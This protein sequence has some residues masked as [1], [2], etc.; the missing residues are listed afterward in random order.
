MGESESA[1]ERG[2]RRR[3]SKRFRWRSR[4]DVRERSVES[5]GE[6]SADEREPGSRSV[7]SSRRDRE[8][9]QTLETIGDSGNEAGSSNE[10][11][12]EE[13]PGDKPQLEGRGGVGLAEASAAGGGSVEA[14]GGSSSPAQLAS[15]RVAVLAPRGLHVEVDLAPQ[16][17][18]GDSRSET[19]SPAAT[20]DRVGDFSPSEHQLELQRAGR[21]QDSVPDKSGAQEGAGGA[22]GPMVAVKV[23]KGGRNGF[24]LAALL[25]GNGDVALARLKKLEQEAAAAKGHDGAALSLKGAVSGRRA[26]QTA[27]LLRGAFLLSLQ[28]LWCCG[29][30]GRTSAGA[31]GQH[32]RLVLVA[33]PSLGGGTACGARQAAAAQ[34]PLVLHPAGAHPRHTGLC[35]RSM[36]CLLRP[37]GRVP[38]G[39]PSGGAQTGRKCPVLS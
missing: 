30:P 22:A 15:P 26:A 1:D 12:P 33:G 25:W 38:N 2:S 27:P 35:A 36:R 5:S 4:R 34:A 39:R 9:Q 18:G 8:A 21:G 17:D 10:E 13:C 32:L 14:V 28:L 11:V 29:A 31:Q 20:P 37:R 3:S 23:E 24:R 19:T 6:S 16:G 7:G